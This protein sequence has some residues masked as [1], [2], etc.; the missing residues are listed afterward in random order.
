MLK[1]CIKK[2]KNAR[3][4]G[5]VCYVSSLGD[6]GGGV[7]VSYS[8]YIAPRDGAGEFGA[9]YDLRTRLE[10]QALPSITL[11]LAVHPCKIPARNHKKCFNLSF[12]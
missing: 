3:E 4:V 8:V 1:N 9:L 7:A 10:R 5:A 2:Q 12:S 6:T 11:G